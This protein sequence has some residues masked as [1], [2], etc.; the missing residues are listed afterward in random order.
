MGGNEMTKIRIGIA[1]SVTRER[2]FRLAIENIDA[3]KI[4]AVCDINE[5]KLEESRLFFNAEEKYAD[6]GEMLKK[7][8]ID[9]VIISTPMPFHAPQATAALKNNLHVIS[10]VPAAVSVEECKKL[11]KAANGCPFRIHERGSRRF[12]CPA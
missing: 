3:L 10:E 9:A 11:V 4:Q 7:S 2:S 12:S 8:D 1:D 5:K 6:Y